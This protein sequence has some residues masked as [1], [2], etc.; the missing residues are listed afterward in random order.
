MRIF[1]AC[2]PRT[3]NLW[4]RRVVARVLDLPNFAAHNPGEID[5]DHLPERCL[6][7]MHWHCTAAFS[8]FLRN[9]GFRT[10]VTV[11]H[12]LDVLVSIL[13]FALLEP[14]TARW[15]EGESGNEKPLIGATP[16]SKEFATYCLS[17]RA[18]SL[19][20]IS[21]EWRNEAEAIIRY[22]DFLAS[23]RSASQQILRALNVE[24]LTSIRRR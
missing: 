5:W 8:G 4:I 9:H 7:A 23:P 15:L 12:P 21:R 24:P 18:A 14:M 17:Y 1:L 10:I 20:S 22:E 16:V 11:R 3:G 2:T 13:H 6:V 19:L